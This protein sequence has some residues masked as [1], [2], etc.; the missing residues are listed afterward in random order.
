MALLRQRFLNGAD[1]VTGNT[2]TGFVNLAL[3]TR[4]KVQG[5]LP[6]PDSLS[7]REY[8]STLFGICVP[9]EASGSAPQGGPSAGDR[10]CH[11]KWF[12]LDTQP[13]I[14][15]QDVE[16]VVRY[17]DR[18]GVV[19]HEE[20]LKLGP[21]VPGISVQ[22]NTPKLVNVMISPEFFCHA[23]RATTW[24]VRCMPQSLRFE[25][26]MIWS[27]KDLARVHTART[28]VVGS[29]G[30]R[31]AQANA[32]EDQKLARALRDL[33]RAVVVNPT[34]SS[35]PSPAPE[36][37]PHATPSAAYV[38]GRWEHHAV[39]LSTGV[40]TFWSNGRVN[41]PAAAPSLGV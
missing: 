34:P 30:Y 1:Q 14:C 15:D 32:S 13:R 7:Q 11:W 37:P 12:E 24:S 40:I 4:P 18:A 29:R 36:G 9:D 16:A 6:E 19:V 5:T 35:T 20:R 33:S 23:A 3:L 21:Q 31:Q 41:D 2:A 38:V 17:T 8:G 28:L 22:S 26:K 27:L 39:G 25:K 10:D